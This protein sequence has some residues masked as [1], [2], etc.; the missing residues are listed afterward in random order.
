M[1]C[2]SAL[3]LCA[4]GLATAAADDCD[5]VSFAQAH[6]DGVP[7]GEGWEVIT[8]S[9]QSMY[10]NLNT[11][12][13]LLKVTACIDSEWTADANVPVETWCFVSKDCAAKSGTVEN[14]EYGYKT[15]SSSEDADL[16]SLSPVDLVEFNTAVFQTDAGDPTKLPVWSCPY[17]STDVTLNSIAAETGTAHMDGCGFNDENAPIIT[18]V[19]MVAVQDANGCSLAAGAGP[20]W[21]SDVTPDRLGRAALIQKK[22]MNIDD[23]EKADAE[24]RAR[25]IHSMDTDG[26]TRVV[27]GGL[28]TQ[29]VDS[30]DACAR[31]YSVYL[32][33]HGQFVFCTLGGPETCVCEK[34]CGDDSLDSGTW[35]VGPAI[36]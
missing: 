4:L 29:I 28:S 15:C 32:I 5:C 31:P 20:G 17:A 12:S 2:S 10:R 13:C 18:A 24:E 6:A 9:G 1:Q 16:S 27:V 7:D 21:I 11:S 30:P 23:L 35:G 3:L 36:R 8:R 34:G 19:P 33:G 26:S 14:T 25:L 22:T